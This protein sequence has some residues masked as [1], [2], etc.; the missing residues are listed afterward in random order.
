MLVGLA[1]C[2]LLLLS[3]P[4]CL[5][6]RP[7]SCLLPLPDPA[8]PRQRLR[9]AKEL[10]ALLDALAINAGNPAIVL[11]QARWPGAA[12][13]CGRPAGG[14]A[15]ARFTAPGF[16]A[17][18]G[19]PRLP[20]RLRC[21]LQDMARS[22]AGGKSA[23]EKY[24]GFMQATE[25]DR[26]ARGPW[27]L[28]RGGCWGLQLPA[29]PPAAVHR[30]ALC[31]C[32]CCSPRCR[33]ADNLRAAQ[34]KKAAIEGGVADL[35]AT[36]DRLAAELKEQEAL[37]EELRGAPVGCGR[38]RSR[39]LPCARP[40][41]GPALL[42]AARCRRRRSSP[43]RPPRRRGAGVGGAPHEPAVL[44]RVGARLPLRARH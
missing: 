14:C 16:S 44:L 17:P 25:F 41:R 8:L 24:Q 12:G 34:A 7:A 23:R 1:C 22:F 19:C 5:P 33:I 11:T 4:G 36:A 38:L 6:T 43:R 2:N 27:C 20:A 42:T 26:C 15:R 30:L 32:S 18:H 37:A 40:S 13:A 39:C 9:G 10:D 31:A 29:P 21:R 3:L 35:Q 28:P